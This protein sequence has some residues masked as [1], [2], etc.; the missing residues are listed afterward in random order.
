MTIVQAIILGVIQGLTEFLPVSSS[1]HLAIMKNILR[2]DLETGALY[3]VLLHVATLVAI[4]IVMRKDIV[5]LILEF[6][7]I[8]RDVFTNFLIFIDRITH[9]DDQYYIKIMSSAYRRFVVLIIVSSIPTAIIGF[10]L[11]DI[12]ETVENEL[13]VPGICLIATAVIILISDFLADGTK[14]PKDATVYDAF[15]I[16]TAQGIA[17]LPGLSRSGTTITACILCGFDRKFAVKYSFIMSMPAIFG[18]LI[19]KLSKI[20]SETV[21]GGDIAV[22][23]VGMVI[24]AVVGYFALI[25]TTKLVQKKSFK[26]FAFYC[27]GIGVV[28]IIAYIISF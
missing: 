26:Y 27:F 24:A 10:L 6:I 17:T 5:K 14:K 3:D 7:S 12:I 11:N 23:I 22:Y 21:T 20:S 16:G 2:M 15:A 9:K 8:V 13:L 18:A 4:C 19:L 25:F 1:G 28:S